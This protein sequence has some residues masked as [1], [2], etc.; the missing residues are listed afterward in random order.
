MSDSL[1][2]GASGLVGGYLLRRL[3][4]E[5]EAVTGTYYGSPFPG[6][7]ALDICCLEQTLLAIKQSHPGCIYLAA[8]LPNVDYCEHHPAES[9][10]INV[11]GTVNVARAA[12]ELG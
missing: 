12:S 1:V 9:Y 6:G 8:A 2:I 10:R 4:Q 5:G 7:T 3:Q 11:C